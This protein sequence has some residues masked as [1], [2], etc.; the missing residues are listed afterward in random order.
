MTHDFQT[1]PAPPGVP[2][3]PRLSRDEPVRQHDWSAVRVERVTV[4]DDPSP[5]ASVHAYVHLGGLTPADVNVALMPVQ[6]M[7]D[8]QRPEPAVAR[9]ELRRALGRDVYLFEAQVPRTLLA[10]PTRLKVHV[11][12]RGEPAVITPFSPPLG[13]WRLVPLA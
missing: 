5:E 6:A 11:T 4:R 8:D 3:L 12:P 1:T 10:G 9:F 2:L 13:R 7:T